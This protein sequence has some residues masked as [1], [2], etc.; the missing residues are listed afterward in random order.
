VQEAIL[1]KAALAV[2][3][4][5]ALTAAAA[6]A[7][8]TYRFWPW[9]EQHHLS[10]VA[11]LESFFIAASAIFAAVVVTQEWS[12]ESAAGVVMHYLASFGILVSALAVVCILLLA[13]GW[14]WFGGAS[15]SALHWLFMRHPLLA[16]A[17]LALAWGILT[18]R[19]RLRAGAWDY[20]LGWL[21]F[22]SRR[23]Q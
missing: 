4:M 19:A 6:A 13:L 15:A 11:A 20:L 12:K 10:G 17:A 3:V 9:L 7:L 14:L 16:L 22:R 1:K 5:A 18:A 23:R 2:L 21:P 8:A